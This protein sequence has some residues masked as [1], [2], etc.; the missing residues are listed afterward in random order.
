M[1]GGIFTL[2]RSSSVGGTAQSYDGDGNLTGNGSWSYSYGAE[3]RLLTA[4]RTSGGTVA[5][6]YDYDPL[7][8]RTHSSGTGVTETDLA[9]SG[10][11]EIAEYDAS[12]TLVT[13]TVPGPAIDQPIA[14]VSAGMTTRY[15]HTNRQGSVIAMSNLTG[16]AVEGPYTYD[17]Y[18]NCYA[19]ATSTPCSSGER[20]RFTGRRQDR[21]TGLLYYRARYYDP[22]TG[23]FLQTDPV[24]YEADLN[25][26]AYVGNDPTNKTDPTGKIAGF[27][28]AAEVALI[29]ACI[30]GG[31]RPR[32]QRP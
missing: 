3:N 18:G 9:N 27:D 23:R 31:W 32:F 19:G 30:D 2:I 1:K 21:E 16:R 12:G 15:F 8:R 22:G 4:T 29:A 10:N 24:G 5:A 11:D 28:D 6:A 13:R 20:Y 7:G 26:Y 17:P 25:L 14:T